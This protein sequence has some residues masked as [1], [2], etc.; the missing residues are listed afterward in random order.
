MSESSSDDDLIHKLS[1]DLEVSV[2][3]IFKIE[4]DYDDVFQILSTV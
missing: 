4:K 1:N 2:Y 3:L